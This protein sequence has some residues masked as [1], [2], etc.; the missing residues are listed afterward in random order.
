[1]RSQLTHSM[2]AEMPLYFPNFSHSFMSYMPC[3][4]TQEWF[5]I[6]HAI[7]EHRNLWEIIFGLILSAICAQVAIF[8]WLWM[9]R[10]TKFPTDLGISKSILR[11]QLLPPTPLSSPIFHTGSW[12]SFLVCMI[13]KM[14]EKREIPAF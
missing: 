4:R 10:A 6:L 5:P 8:S 9:G 11:F 1:M 2:L 7:L 14:K 13:R 3:F 12:L